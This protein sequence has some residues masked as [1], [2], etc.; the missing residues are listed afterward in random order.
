MRIVRAREKV[1]RCNLQ[2]NAPCNLH[3]PVCLLY[4]EY[5]VHFIHQFLFVVRILVE[6][7][8]FLGLRGDRFKYLQV[9]CA[10]VL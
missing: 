7:P 4:V 2:C 3:T 6:I 8:G 5:D 9:M 1:V 10:H